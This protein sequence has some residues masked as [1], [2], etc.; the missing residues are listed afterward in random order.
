MERGRGA[1]ATVIIK[2]G[3]LSVG[4]P[5]VVGTEYGKVREWAAEADVIAD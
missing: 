2:A 5:L 1:V 3:N 4:D